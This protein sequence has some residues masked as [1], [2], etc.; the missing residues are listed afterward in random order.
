MHTRAKCLPVFRPLSPRFCACVSRF[1]NIFMYVC[2][3]DLICITFKKGT[4]LL[5]SFEFGIFGVDW[6][7]RNGRCEQAVPKNP[8]T[9]EWDA[10]GDENDGAWHQW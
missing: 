3:F 10:N 4:K 8:S 9:M 5:V 7:R 1:L 2:E 6:T